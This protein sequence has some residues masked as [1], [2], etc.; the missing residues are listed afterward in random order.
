MRDRRPAER[1]RIVAQARLPAP[2]QLL[3]VERQSLEQTGKGFLL[4]RPDCLELAE[5]LVEPRVDPS[6]PGERDLCPNAV[7]LEVRAVEYICSRPF[8]SGAMPP[9][10]RRIASNVPSGGSSST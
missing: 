5:Q 6:D 9:T 4:R 1:L 8:R 3:A 2:D 7:Q 10:A